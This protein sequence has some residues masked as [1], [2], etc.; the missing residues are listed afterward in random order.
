MAKEKSKRQKTEGRKA[1]SDNRIKWMGGCWAKGDLQ[2]EP[3]S[4][5]RLGPFSDGRCQI[6]AF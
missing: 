5:P 1:E 2:G 3:F 6:Y 4:P